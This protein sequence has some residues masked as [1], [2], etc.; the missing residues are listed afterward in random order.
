MQMSTFCLCDWLELWKEEKC[1]REL[2]DSCSLWE[3]EC[4]ELLGLGLYLFANLAT[5][6]CGD[7]LCL[8]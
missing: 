5:S 2:F 6:R 1:G 8:L 3:V 7:N 4:H